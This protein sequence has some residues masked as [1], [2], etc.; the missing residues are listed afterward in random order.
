MP[1]IM[2]GSVRRTSPRRF[3]LAVWSG[4]LVL[5]VLGLASC[6]KPPE[7]ELSAAQAAIDQAKSKEA[8]E[9]AATEL[10]AAEDSLAAARSEVDRQSAKF[11]LFRSYKVAKAKALAAQTAGTTAADAAV[12]NK[13]IAR[14]DAEKSLADAVQA[15]ADVRALLDSPQGKRL[16][17]AKEARQAIEQ[18]KTE[19]DATEASL[20]N[21]RTAQAQEKFK[22]AARMAKEAVSKARS[23]GSEVQAAV[24]KMTGGKK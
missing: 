16:M 1:V 8:A 17:R 19:L 9:Y 22:P 12:K 4:V 5:L 11:A 3:T 14:Q 6:A 2:S 23:L 7:A 18:I 10:K 21:V 15:I 13:E 24:D 20:E